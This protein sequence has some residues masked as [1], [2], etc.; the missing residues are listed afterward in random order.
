LVLAYVLLGSFLHYLIEGNDRGQ[1]PLWQVW[2]PLA[3]FIAAAV[4][5]VV[6]VRR[7]VCERCGPADV[8][9]WLTPLPRQRSDRVLA[10]GQTRRAFL[11]SLGAG[12]AAVAGSAAGLGAAIGH[13]RGWIPVA[14]DFFQTPVENTA[15]RPRAEWAESRIR[16]YRRLGR[17]GA[18]VS[19]VS[20]GSGRINDVSIARRALER[21]LNY[22]DTAPDYAHTPSE[23]VLG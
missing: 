22:F 2:V 1:L 18:M 10:L 14:R 15:P 20:L 5:G 8:P 23:R 12:G 16:K 17:T 6:R 7:P 3:V 13:N 4:A 21:G 9:G 19:D 11:R